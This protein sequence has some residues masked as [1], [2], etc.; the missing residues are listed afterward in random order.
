MNPLSKFDYAGYILSKYPGSITNLKLQ[1]LMY[2]LYAWSLVAG[3]KLFDA[4]FK[5]WSYGPVEPDIY[6][7][8]KKFG[9]GTIQESGNAAFNLPNKELTDFI[10]DSY[11]PFSAVELFK[12]THIEKPWNDAVQ[13]G[14]ITDVS[15]LNYYD[16]HPFA[17]NFPLG[18][19]EGYF[20]PKTSAHYSFVFDMDEDVMPKFESLEEFV[21]GFNKNKEMIK[22][23]L[24]G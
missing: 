2:Y 22:N 23:H 3:D 11:M 15:I 20:P 9:S 21:T 13:N 14:Q 19:K 5:A 24:S 12:T 10:L 18:E 7:Q 4:E 8:Y 1:K 6:Q 16:K 17:K